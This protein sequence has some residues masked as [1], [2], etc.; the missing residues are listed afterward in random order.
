MKYH[1]KR[2]KQKK[3]QRVCKTKKSGMVKLKEMKGVKK[4]TKDTLLEKSKVK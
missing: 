4:M 3:K 2:G 1:K